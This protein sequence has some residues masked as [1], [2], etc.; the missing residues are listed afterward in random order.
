MLDLACEEGL[1]GIE[2][3][4]RGAEVLGVEGREVHV[5]RGRFAKEALGLDNCEFVQ[6]DVRELRPESHGTFD[7]VLCLGILYHFDAPDAME[8]I[9]RLRELTTRF[10]ILQSRIALKPKKQASFRGVTYSGTPV[11]EHPVKASNEQ[12][13]G[14]LRASLDNVEA[15]RLT[16][17][18]VFNLLLNA[19]FTSVLE[20]QHPRPA[21]RLADRVL[22]AAIAGEPVELRSA[23]ALN[24]AP[25]APWPEREK[26]RFDGRLSWR[27]QLKRRLNALGVPIRRY[28]WWRR[29]EQ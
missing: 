24:D 9:Y 12:R 1:F 8:F 27:G 3:A 20:V 7:V 21:F 28:T 23:P 5:E 14:R 26:R 18:S 25:R 13:I 29:P 2:F 6:G 16:K 4:R 15:F 10:M 22:L 11:F 17:P 19:G